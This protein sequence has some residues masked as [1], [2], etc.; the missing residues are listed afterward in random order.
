MTPNAL[1][2]D[3]RD[4]WYEVW[5][6]VAAGRFWL[7]YTLHVPGDPGQD[8][9]AALWLASWAGAPAARKWTFPLEAFR[10]DAAGARVEIGDAR[11]DAEG[12]SGAPAG[13]AAWELSFSGGGRPFEHAHPLVRPLTRSRVVL[14]APALE[15]SGW[16]EIDGVRHELDRA[17][18]HQA[19]VFGTRHAERFAWAHASAG[20]GRWLELLAA[21]LRGLPELA[22]YATERGAVNAPWR[23]PFVRADLSPR[24]TRIGPYEV[25]AEPDDFVGVT[26]ED[27]DG[28]RLFC[29][30]T[31]RARVTGP[32][33]EAGDAS[34]EFATRT[35]LNGWTISL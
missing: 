15:I 26:Y 20:G 31:E 23:V 2:W 12:A 14:A 30:H 35:P 10:T 28:S 8:G 6:L 5:Y 33:V 22:A 16:V 17:A 9:H 32:G 11:L 4:G 13:D 24:R 21:K 3:G 34:Y 27:P 29:Y 19:H 18:G 25:T 1:R 7:R